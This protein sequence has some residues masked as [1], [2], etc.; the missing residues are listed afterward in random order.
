[1]PPAPQIS[2]PLTP[3]A[4][5]SLWHRVYFGF[6]SSF[7]QENTTTGWGP[8]HPSG[9][10]AP[11][12][13][14][15]F[16]PVQSKAPSQPLPP[17]PLCCAGVRGVVGGPEPL[18]CPVPGWETS[19]PA[20]SSALRDPASAL[21]PGWGEALP[22]SPALSRLALS[23]GTSG[24]ARRWRTLLLP[25]PA[26]LRP[27]LRAGRNVWPAQPG[28]HRRHGFLLLSPLPGPPGLPE[29]SVSGKGAPGPGAVQGEQGHRGHLSAERGKSGQGK[30]EKWFQEKF[31]V[32][33]AC[34][35]S[36]THPAELGSHL[37]P[38]APM[39]WDWGIKIP[40]VDSAVKTL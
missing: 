18:T 37:A 13:R 7:L 8:R 5:R 31:G 4:S 19:C 38:Y 33:F 9:G 1:M 40:L 30:G 35:P 12:L 6:S 15:S 23:V 14:T 16:V 25:V 22:R 39:P 2:E 28:S 34:V 11:A 10:S 29:R 32:A 26:L 36:P 27:T 24:R 17:H 21:A 20:L 3:R